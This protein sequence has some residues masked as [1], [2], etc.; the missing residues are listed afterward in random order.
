MAKYARYPIGT[1]PTP[2]SV[3]TANSPAYTGDAFSPSGQAPSKPNPL[4][5]SVKYIDNRP[6]T[7]EKLEGGGARVTR[8][9]SRSEVNYTQS[10]AE[11]Q[12]LLRPSRA[13]NTF[14]GPL[15]NA[16]VKQQGT[17]FTRAE[18]A[19]ALARKQE[20]SQAA[21]SYATDLY[22]RQQSSPA[23]VRRQEREN[24]IQTLK[25]KQELSLQ[26]RSGLLTNEGMVQVQAEADT[27]DLQ[28]NNR[29]FDG[30]I[31]LADPGSQKVQGKGVLISPRVGN[32]LSRVKGN[33]LRPSVIK[34]LNFKSLSR[35]QTKTGEFLRGGYAG[36]KFFS[37]TMA[38]PKDFVGGAL[39]E[40]A[41]LSRRIEN[42][43][44]YQRKSYSFNVLGRSIK[45][46]SENPSEG[47]TQG[48]KFFRGGAETLK[49]KPLV[50]VT[51][52]AVGTAIGAGVKTATLGYSAVAPTLSKVLPSSVVKWT[53]KAVAAGAVAYFGGKYAKDAY[54]RIKAS[55]EPAKTAGSIYF[56]EVEQLYFG[57]KIGEGAVNKVVDASVMLRGRYI[58]QEK[59]VDPKVLQGQDFP[60]SRNTKAALK[61]FQSGRYNLDKNKPG[62]QAFHST[63]AG[64]FGKEF[65]TIPGRGETSPID[66]RGLYVAPSAS[67]YFLRQ[68]RVAQEYSVLPEFTGG[69]PNILS[70]KIGSVGRVP[71][72]V[73]TGNKLR[74]VEKGNEFFKSQAGRDKAYISTRSEAG[75]TSETEAII[76]ESTFLERVTGRRGYKYYTITEGRAVP[77]QEFRIK[78]GQVSESA[79]KRSSRVSRELRKLS[80]RNEAYYSSAGRSRINIVPYRGSSSSSVRIS[81]SYASRSSSG[82]SLGSSI[83]SIGYS[84]GSS[85]GSSGSSLTSPG[86]SRGSSG[87]SSYGSSSSS[88]GSSGRSSS[89][90]SGGSSSI[91][92]YPRRGPPKRPPFRFKLKLKGVE[93]KAV[94]RVIRPFKYQP[95]LVGV[96]TKTKRVKKKDYLS[97]L[98]IR[99]IGNV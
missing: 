56:G 59:L 18:F 53:P 64:L 14:R 30:K 8:E 22:T 75:F 71:R 92:D 48:A 28:F 76:P 78:P 41:K 60:K 90:S 27:L 42:K 38:I 57:G 84:G 11:R 4:R 54:G 87:R 58:P 16:E 13:I 12:G 72:R 5:E 7:V 46:R 17:N 35:P 20:I 43:L 36:A 25:R 99:G 31:S 61:E 86:Y 81:Y 49:E 47:L 3:Q 50:G 24:R 80:R 39:E 74:V 10:S 26:A 45:T 34:D 29:L 6:K 95:S 44:G 73:R 67:V 9:G 89:G 33:Y 52:L 97:G 55:P 94:N 2:G 96:E 40:G 1:G 63:D 23:R 15:R 88:R 65:K 83:G 70:I 82:S 93:S 51:S 69:R 32:K 19:G 66:N 62:V 37:Q 91:L 21:R 85:K 77:I 68:A 98:E 79:L